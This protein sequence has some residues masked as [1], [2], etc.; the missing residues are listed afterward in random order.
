MKSKDNSDNNQS[1]RGLNFEFLCHLCQAV[2]DQGMRDTLYDG[3]LAFHALLIYWRPNLK[4]GA[5]LSDTRFS[6]L[7]KHLI[8]SSQETK[9]QSYRPDIL[10]GFPDSQK[11]VGHA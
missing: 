4:Q 5:I 1:R 7:I 11:S 2:P 8:V 6:I 9:S 10:C 3:W